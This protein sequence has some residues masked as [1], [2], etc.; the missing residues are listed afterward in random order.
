MSALRIL[1]VEDNPLT[2]K[3]L[4]ITLES[5]GYTVIEAADGR[6]ALA[7]LER[8]K[9]ALILQDLVLPDM[10]GFELL[11]QLRQ[12]GGEATPIIALTGFL[13]RIEEARGAEVGFTA[14]L[15]KPVEPS[16]L[17]EFIRPY[18]PNV[19]AIMP[20]TQGCRVLVVD[21]DP[22][23][24]K[25]TRLHLTQLG[26][27]V[28]LA[29]SSSEALRTARVQLPDVVLADVLMPDFDGFQLCFQ[30]R[31]DPALY[32]LP[33][34]LASAWYETSADRELATRVGANALVRKT[35]DLQGVPEAIRAAMK[36]G[37]P[38]LTEELDAT[39]RLDHAQAVVRQLQRQVNLRSDLTRRCTLQAAQIS[40]LS[41]VADALAFNVDADAALR[42]VLAATLDAAGISKGALFLETEGGGMALRHAIGFTAAERT[43]LLGF[44]GHPRIL[45]D[46]VFR[47][48][49][50]SIP[51]AP[52]EEGLGREILAQVDAASAQ[53]VPLVSDGRGVGAMVLCAKYTDVTN[54]DSIAFARAMG[55]Q[56]AQS[57][58]LAKSF[59]RLTASER[60]YRAVTEAAHEAISILT[61]D[62][63]IQECNP[64]FEVALGLPRES[65]VG[66][67][68]EDF[69]PAGHEQDSGKSL[70]ASREAGAGPAPIALLRSDGATVLMEFTSRS[71]DLGAEQFSVSI[72]RD[73]TERVKTQ[74][75]LM[76]SDRMAS[77]GSLAAG[78]A[79]EINNPLTATVASLEFA[80]ERV[81]ELARKYGADEVAELDELLRDA[82]AGAQ[83][84]RTIVRDLKIF[85]RA[86]EDNRGPVDLQRV[87][88]SSVR[89]AWNEIRH[90]AQLVRE[91]ESVPAVEANESRLGQVFLNLIVNAVQALPDGYADKN[92][93]WIRTRVEPSGR[94]LAEVEDTGP[95]IPAEVLQR[96]F[97][98]FF[99]TKPRGVGTGL[100]LSICRRIVKSFGGEITVDSEVGRGTR[101]SV[102]LLA[103]E[104][105]ADARS[106]APLRV[107]RVGRR[108]RV[109]VVDDDAM[110]ATAVS[111]G[112]TP[113][114][115]VVLSDDA[116]AALGR[117]LQ[118][119]RFDAIICDLMMPVKTGVEF[120]ADISAQAPEFA[121]R[122]IFLTGGA[123]TVKAREFLDRVPNSRLE[124][125]FDLPALRALVNAQM[126]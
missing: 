96:L 53:I 59:A 51:S 12:L 17:L 10:N 42:D 70:E 3:M 93:I 45:Q 113:E 30:V 58:D 104:R 66:H 24:L 72:G 111:R 23:Q 62:G 68:I 83:C 50:V 78:V 27:D 6:A 33:V 90:R 56:L 28:V 25:L 82:S 1:V 117:I 8:E 44:F 105:V 4:R 14:L 126:R 124:K 103:S 36:Q 121:G 32:R 76:F 92:R 35:P 15:L 109:L 112:L 38:R 85:S 89:M 13:S 52:L 37:A 19:P 69:T 60:R 120:F 99:T 107:T 57:L 122:I 115:D 65:I 40:L 63:I 97:T 73:V 125:P 41:G 22:V 46:A 54:D 108:G 64:S 20:S 49:T 79:H 47:Q 7:V 21:D 123:F 84:V 11:R 116:D 61:P 26:F 67:R 110:S 18:L 48:A 71:V 91:F 119:E 74:A 102:S 100:G 88:E 9:P 29:A 86:E 114:H 77:I 101:F 80:L 5:E 55:N 34:I 81:A 118:G 98:P 94:V 87:L 2:R 43:G 75:Q 106:T 95:G 31:K 39:V 16:H